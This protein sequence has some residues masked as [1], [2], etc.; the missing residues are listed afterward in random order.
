L[1]F[2]IS[3]SLCIFCT[4]SGIGYILFKDSDSFFCSFIV[5][6]GSSFGFSLEL[7]H[8]NL[9][10]FAFITVISGLYLLHACCINTSLDVLTIFS[11][12]IDLHLNIYTITIS[13]FLRST[14][15]FIKISIL[16][17][18]SSISTKNHFFFAL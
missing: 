11:K 17:E 7:A 2:I 8:S 9:N 10:N 4:L 14:V 5:I 12:L 13:F 1:D 16:P 3:D 15:S 6:I 18:I